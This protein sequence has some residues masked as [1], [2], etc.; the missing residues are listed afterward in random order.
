[1]GFIFAVCRIEPN[2]SLPHQSQATKNRS[3]QGISRLVIRFSMLQAVMSSFFGEPPVGSTTCP[4][5]RKVRGAFVP[6]MNF[7]GWA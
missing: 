5:N 2:T 6:V 7:Q 1:M 3:E 4:S